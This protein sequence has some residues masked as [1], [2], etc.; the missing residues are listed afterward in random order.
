MSKKTLLST[1]YK[2]NYV[3]FL[4][5]T[6]FFI[7]VAGQLLIAAAIPLTLRDSSKLA[8]ESRKLQVLNTFD[9][10]RR[11]CAKELPDSALLEEQQLLAAQLDR[12]A[13]YLRKYGDTLTPAE[14]NKLETAVNRLYAIANRI[15][16]G[17]GLTASSKLNISAAVDKSLE[18]S[19]KNAYK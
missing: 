5:V 1:A 3:A 12:T 18:E 4:A 9:Q 2:R 8:A 17:K 11:L 16:S 6:L 7:I 15:Y 13:I 10:T 19:S 14:V